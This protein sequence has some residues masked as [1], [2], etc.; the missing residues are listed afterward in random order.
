MVNNPLDQVTTLAFDVFGTILNLSGSLVPPIRDFLGGKTPLMDGAALWRQWRERQRIEQHQ[1]SLLMLGHSGY[2]ET[3]RRALSYCLRRHGIDF[4]D[5][6]VAGLMRAY[7]ELIPFDDAARGLARLKG[8]YRLVVLSNGEQWLLEHMVNN[9]IGFEFD[10]IISVEK[11]GFFKPH[12]S[13]YRTAVQLLGTEPHQ[14]MMV[15]SHTFDIMG[16]RACGYRGAYVNRYRLPLED[17]LYQPD[18][19]VRDFD[20]LAAR[21][22]VESSGS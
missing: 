21:L 16:A 9:Q 18:I 8:H 7:Q 12:P 14:V 22:V 20:E 6:E 11:A 1:D 17:T 19:V 4:T 10:D 3:C 13:V 5:D 15:A 2:L